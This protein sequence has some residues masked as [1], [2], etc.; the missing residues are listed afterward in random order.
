MA[1]ILGTLGATIALVAILLALVVIGSALYG[2]GLL[3]FSFVVLPI[4]LFVGDTAHDLHPERLALVIGAAVGLFRIHWHLPLIALAAIG[5]VFFIIEVS[6]SGKYSP[7]V[8]TS[9]FH[10]STLDRPLCL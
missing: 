9:G 2:V 8:S 4:A 6:T 7:S 1:W 5:I 3:L 10:Q